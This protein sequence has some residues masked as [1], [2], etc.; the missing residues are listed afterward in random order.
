MAET[1]DIEELMEQVR[2]AVERIAPDQGAVTYIDEAKENTGDPRVL[3]GDEE[4][5]EV[6]IP[7]APVRSTV[8]AG[9]IMSFIKKLTRRAPNLIGAPAPLR[10]N[11]F[12]LLLIRIINEQDLRIKNVESALIKEQERFNELRQ[13]ITNFDY[14]G[15]ED[16]FRG[17][18]DQ[19]KARQ[20]RLVTFFSGKSNVLDIG[21]GRGEFLEL[22]RENQIKAQGIDA[23]EDMV[24]RCQKKGLQVIKG[25]ALAYLGEQKDN[26]F[27]GI[28]LGQVVEHFAPANLIK[29]IELC[30][31]KLKKNGY[32]VMETVN[33]L[34]LSVF[35]N[36]FF[37]DITHQKP[38]HPQFLN[39]QLRSLGFKDIEII[40]M[41]PMDE[42]LKLQKIDND[43]NDHINIINTM[44][45]NWEKLNNLLFSYQDYAIGA[46]K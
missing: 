27:D 13:S 5:T 23:D 43:K 44:N 31:I 42:N 7:E 40:F 18:E 1:T 12:H 41:S 14:I 29:L 46:K 10:V 22:L 25:D 20:S 15:F 37:L 6:E 33:P 8:P 9:P 19:I 34:C 26:F 38:V 16:E 36:S 32:L 35:A 3:I 17:P 21:C 11:A 30:Y 24:R 39:F 28:F 45:D 2:E 4:E